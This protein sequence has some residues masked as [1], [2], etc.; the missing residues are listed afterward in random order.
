MAFTV[1]GLQ[2]VTGGRLVSGP[3]ERVLSGGVCTDSRKVVPQCVF[4]ALGGENFDGNEFAPEAS[5]KGA[6]AVVVSRVVKG[7]EPSCAIILVDDVLSALQTAAEWWRGQLK[8]LKV[9]GI[10]GSSGKTSTKDLVKSVLERKFRV[11]A[12]KGNLNNHIGLPLSVLDAQP[13]DEAAVWEMGMNHAGE[14]KP[15]CRI[16]KPQ[17]GIIP[18]IGSAH[19]EFFGSREAIAR[20]KCT[21]P[22]SLP[23]DGVMIY[24]ANCEFGDMIRQSTKASCMTVGIG[25]G[26]VRAEGVV[27][28]E[29]GTT[30]TLV[31]DGFCSEPVS[32]PL[33][34]KHMVSNALLAAAAGWKLGLSPREIAQGLEDA[35]LTGGRL[36]CFTT[37]GIHVVDDTYNANP[38]SMEAALETVGSMLCGGRRFAVLGKMG[39]LGD[40]A[41]EAHRQVGVFAYDTGFDVI[42][43][44]GAEAAGISEGAES[45]GRGS[46]RLVSH[47][48]S[49][50]TAAVWLRDELRPGDLV[51]FKGSRS[52]GMDSLINLIFHTSSNL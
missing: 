22:E 9:V 5:A 14:L 42:V 3:A 12:T 13:S 18:S 27:S 31:I 34:G 51:L 37:N 43:S 49:R 47:F 7:I 17:I 24:P 39:E 40:H 4:F 35:R 8:R 46:E 2:N 21:L 32:L 11:T 45:K 15:L 19:I 38:E 52:A 44:V 20:E 36:N 10:T 1:Q 29:E 33:H 48:D 6:A 30:F 23:A 50:E 25:E 26:D 28:D 41:D 16:S